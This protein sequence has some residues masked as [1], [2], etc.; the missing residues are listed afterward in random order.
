MIERVY[1]ANDM[2]WTGAMATEYAKEMSRTGTVDLPHI[3][4]TWNNLL[5]ANSGALWKYLIDDYTAGIIGGIVTPDVHDGQKVAV[6]L[7]W[8]VSPLARSTNA[9]LLLWSELETWAIGMGAKRIYAAANASNT[10]LQ[11]FY[12]KLGLRTMEVS[13][14]K[15]I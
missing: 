3:I 12:E 14:M 5:L 4:S 8:Y 1:N 7:L 13:Y 9:G 2:G 6:E 11:K 10:R 15:E